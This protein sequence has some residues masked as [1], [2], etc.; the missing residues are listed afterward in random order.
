MF[1]CLKFAGNSLPIFW[2]ENAGKGEI[3]AIFGMREKEGIRN[4]L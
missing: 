4:F 3:W 2:I 1:S